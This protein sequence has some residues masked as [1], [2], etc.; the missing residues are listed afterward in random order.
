MAVILTSRRSPVGVQTYAFSNYTSATRDSIRLWHVHFSLQRSHSNEKSVSNSHIDYRNDM[1]F[2]H[3][4]HSLQRSSENSSMNRLGIIRPIA[5]LSDQDTLK[6]SLDHKIMPSPL[7]SHTLTQ[8]RKWCTRT[9]SIFSPK[10][11]RFDFAH[12]RL[13]FHLHSHWRLPL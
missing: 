3:I 9:F 4:S 7:L 12:V 11:S 2:K 1:P 8:L 5:H 6:R 10:P 13:H